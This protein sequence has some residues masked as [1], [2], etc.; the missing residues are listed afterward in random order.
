[1]KK[2]GIKEF[3]RD[4]HNYLN[5]L[6]ITLTRY[7]KVVAHV[8]E[9]KKEVDEGMDELKVPENM[10]VRKTTFDIKQCKHG[11]KVGLC[12]HGCKK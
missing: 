7:G 12:K 6:P 10:P 2:V 4:I 9:Y 3:R 1:M 8:I 11:S 5:D